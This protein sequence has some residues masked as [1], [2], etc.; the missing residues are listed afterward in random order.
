MLCAGIALAGV[1]AC[2]QERERAPGQLVVSID[3]DMALPTQID[4]LRVQV[5]LPGRTL[6]DQEYEVGTGVNPIPATLTV[7]AGKDPS[8]PVTIRVAGSKARRYRTLREA[9]TPVPQDRI[10]SLR[11]PIQWLCDGSAEEMASDDPSKPDVESTCG[12]G[13]SC[14]AGRCMPSQVKMSEL[15]DYQPEQVFGGAAA[16]E[17]GTC[18]DTLPCMIAG[19]VAQPDER[20]EIERPRGSNVN[21]ALRVAD[22]GICD[23]TGTACFVPLDGHS[24]EGWRP[25]RDGERLILPEAACEKLRAGRVSAVYVSTRCAT[26]TAATPPCGDWTSV[27]NKSE[28]Q[29]LPMG[30]PEPPKV[31]VS[32]QLPVSDESALCCPLLQG[33]ALFSCVCESKDQARVLAIDPQNGEIS[34]AGTIRPPATRERTQFAAAMFENELFWLD[35]GAIARQALDAGDDTPDLW[36]VSAAIYENAPLHADGSDVFALASAVEG[37]SG[38]PVQLLRVGRSG[39]VTPFDTGGNT[40]VYQF[41]QGEE[42]VFLAT[43]VDRENGELIARESRL[44]RIDKN[45]GTRSELLPVQRVQTPERLRG[46][47]IGVVADADQVFALFESAPEADGTTRVQLHAAAADGSSSGEAPE[48]RYELV[49]DP[50]L[51]Q[52]LLLGALDG[53]VVLARIEYEGEADDS[54]KVRSSAIVVVPAGGGAPR[55]LADLARDYPVQGLVHDDEHVYFLSSRGQLFSVDRSVLQ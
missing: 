42:F 6:L 36:P 25:T 20:C 23:D 50:T 21:V 45:D 2:E 10:A 3:T 55:I 19:T 33:A 47:Y 53:G 46:G 48:P 7:L 30:E 41:A 16:P 38:S 44:L 29:A 39:T 1:V 8:M 35:D 32:A 14:V 28:P 4:T 40:P 13:N 5:L 18:F 49:L 34:A 52:L 15:P 24:E 37:S 26:K 31:V 27:A 22:D 51:S 17:D 43:D 12:D 11:M 9:T 54:G